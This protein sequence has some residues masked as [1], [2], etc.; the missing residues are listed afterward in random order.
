MKIKK[1]SQQSI[2]SKIKL[3][4]GLKKLNEG[5]RKELCKLINDSGVNSLC[6]IIYNCVYHPPIS[7]TLK[8]LK[9]LQK[10]LHPY[11]NAIKITTNPKK[12]VSS[13][14]AVVV[15]HGGFIGAILGIALP[16]LIELGQKLFTKNKKL[17][18]YSVV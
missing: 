2:C 6:E 5:Q 14:R 10:I 15:Q 8:K 9:H 12:S 11:R 16:L 7:F 17:K 4:K 13:R 18:T 3:V 1:L